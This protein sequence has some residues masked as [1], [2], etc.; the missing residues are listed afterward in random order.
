MTYPD[1]NHRSDKT[2]GADNFSNSELV[3]ERTRMRPQAVTRRSVI[4]QDVLLSVHHSFVIKNISDDGNGLVVT[5]TFSQY[6][7]CSNHDLI[8]YGN[9]RS[10]DDEDNDMIGV[11]FGYRFN[12]TSAEDEKYFVQYQGTEIQ[13]KTDMGKLFLHRY[14]VK[15]PL[16]LDV[17]LDCFPFRVISASLLVELTTFITDGQKLK[18][19]PDLL[20]HRRDKTNMFRIEPDSWH[21]DS[22]SPMYQAK[23]IIDQ[24]ESYDLV[25]PFPRVS[26]IYNPE[27]NHCCQFRVRFLMVQNGSKKML[28]ILAPM[29][30][31][32]GLNT[33][34]VLQGEDDNILDYTGN[35]ATFALSVLVFLP[36]IGSGA[37][38]VQEL[39]RASNMY[40]ISI[41][42]ALGFSSVA[43]QWLGN[44]NL[45][46]AGMILLWGSFLFPILNFLRYVR[47]ARHAKFNKAGAASHFW[48]DSDAEL[49][50][51]TE[52]NADSS[53]VKVSDLVNNTIVNN[54]TTDDLKDMDY[55]IRRVNESHILE[56][57]SLGDIKSRRH[58]AYPMIRN[59][60]DEEVF[61]A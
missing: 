13:E 27:K 14:Y 52:Y 53:F 18:V 38:H 1:A 22:R 37:S 61:V 48:A 11:S 10:E 45:A 29:I 24:S 21:P 6:V 16:E 41:I 46:T 7:F 17:Q 12:D 43:F 26:Y 30:L 36:T 20:I 33:I 49:Y 4:A 51:A 56:F 55:R 57:A 32:A 40:V 44:N 2:I 28:E 9:N 15:L 50:E 5:G 19:R 35:S 3:K 60:S 59:A 58:K 54:T 42:L 23:D 25:S 47:F 31:I 39:W 34:N 8:E